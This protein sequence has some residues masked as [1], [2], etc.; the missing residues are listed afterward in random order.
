MLEDKQPFAIP[1]LGFQ[2]DELERGNRCSVFLFA[3]QPTP[4]VPPAF[5]DT[6][7]FEVVPAL[8]PRLFG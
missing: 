2:R 3:G 1:I 5:G 6:P 7:C 4:Q 8:F